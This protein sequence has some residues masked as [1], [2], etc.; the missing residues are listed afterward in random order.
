MGRSKIGV[1][2]GFVVKHWEAYE[3]SCCACAYDPYP[4]RH[5]SSEF[6]LPMTVDGVVML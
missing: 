6:A 4:S 5:P 1:K 3:E 2:A